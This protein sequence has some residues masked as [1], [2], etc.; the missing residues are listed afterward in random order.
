[1]PTFPPVI[2]QNASSKVRAEINSLTTRWNK[3]NKLNFI[4]P[5]IYCGTWN[6]T[7]DHVA[8]NYQPN[9]KVM[10]THEGQ[11]LWLVMLPTIDKLT[12]GSEINIWTKGKIRDYA[13]ITAINPDAQTVTVKLLDLN[14]VANYL[15]VHISK[16]FAI[17]N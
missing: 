2:A 10:S 14:P 13:H 6:P 4:P 1:M 3:V 15:T 7:R 17:V 5:V 12:I 11:N 16:V 9:E 8:A